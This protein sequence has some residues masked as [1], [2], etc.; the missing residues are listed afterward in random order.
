MKVY[1]HGYRIKVPH[2]WSSCQTCVKQYT[3]ISQYL[4]TKKS[5]VYISVDDILQKFKLISNRIH[6]EM[7][8]YNFIRGALLHFLQTNFSFIDSAKSSLLLITLTQWI[9]TFCESVNFFLTIY[10]LL[11]FRVSFIIF[12]SRRVGRNFV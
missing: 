3:L 12:L 5:I 1:L 4:F 11:Y 8:C 2:L 9:I 10:I 6:V 7:S